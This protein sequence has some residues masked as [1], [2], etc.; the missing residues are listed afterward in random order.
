VSSNKDAKLNKK[1]QP[2]LTSSLPLSFFSVSQWLPSSPL[3]TSL[4]SLQLNQKTTFETEREEDLRI[5]LSQI[6]N[7][8]LPM[9]HERVT[10]CAE[11]HLKEFLTPTSSSWRRWTKLKGS[12]PSRPGENQ[13]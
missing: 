10:E 3:S 6:S 9:G 12:I 8:H 13:G 5:Q 2:F 11:D 7:K 4:S 1:D